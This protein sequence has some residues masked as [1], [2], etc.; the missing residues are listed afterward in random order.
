MCGVCDSHQTALH[1][2]KA[3]IHHIVGPVHSGF[4]VLNRKLN[5]RTRSPKLLWLWILGAKRQQDAYFSCDS[6]NIVIL[7]R[8]RF[9]KLVDNQ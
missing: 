1:S 5:S 9:P 3:L 2:S 8:K 7:E 4:L 6:E